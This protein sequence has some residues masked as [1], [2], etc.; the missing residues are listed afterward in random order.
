MLARVRGR[1]F[2]ELRHGLH[3]Q[4][5]IGVVEGG[6]GVGARDFDEL[7]IVVRG[8]LGG[9]RVAV[10]EEIGPLVGCRLGFVEVDLRLRNAFVGDL[11]KPIRCP[12][13]GFCHGT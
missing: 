1:K 11:V 5:G 9:G 3:A 7:E 10:L 13:F 8:A 12:R 4:H 6:V 2:K